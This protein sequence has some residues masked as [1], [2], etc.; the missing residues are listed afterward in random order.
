ML[1]APIDLAGS[2]LLGAALAL[3]AAHEAETSPLD[4]AGL[5]ALVA[6]AFAATA[7]ADCESGPLHGFL[8]ACDE[9]AAY[10]S[11]NFL[12]FAERLPRF[13]YVDRVIV[14]TAARGRGVA[15]AL[16]ADLI[17]RAQAAGH[18]QIV[19]EVNIE[20]PNP[21]SDAFHAASGFAEVGQ[22]CLA[23]RGKVVR[24]LAL[25]LG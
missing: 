8:I 25:A 4:R 3:N 6:S 21:V 17:A 14:S 16:Y 23:G 13:V 10:D 18:R 20:P 22:A 24:Y 9:T 11:P 1:P 12:W 5:A 7:I 15:R 2:P 19:C